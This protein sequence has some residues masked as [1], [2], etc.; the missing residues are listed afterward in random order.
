M[1]HL[2]NGEG[3]RHAA[4]DGTDVLVMPYFGSELEF[5]AFAPSTDNFAEFRSSLNVAQMQALLA[6]AQV[7]TVN[8]GF[9]KMEVAFTLPLKEELIEAGMVSAFTDADADF[10]RLASNDTWLGEAFHQTKVIL[11]E[12]GTEA[13]AATAFVGVDESAGPEPIDVTIDRAFVFL[14]RD[15]ETGAI[16]FLG[17]YV[18]PS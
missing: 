16:L 15:V 9:P 11:D 5:V 4:V 17:Q 7:A 3:L 2:S 18:G 8:L 10:S 1:M 6:Q 14:I 13:A 12:E